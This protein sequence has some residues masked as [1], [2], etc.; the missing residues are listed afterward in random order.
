MLCEDSLHREDLVDSVCSE[1]EFVGFHV[2]AM[3]KIKLRKNQKYELNG[4]EYKYVESLLKN[5]NGV[6]VRQCPSGVA[7]IGRVL[8][9][10]NEDKK[11]KEDA[12]KIVANE[13][14]EVWIYGM[15]IYPKTIKNIISS[16]RNVYEG[17]DDGKRGSAGSGG[18]ESFRSFTKIQKRKRNDQ[19]QDRANNFNNKMLT[20]FDIRTNDKAYQDR[21]EKEHDVKMS[22]AEEETHADNCKVKTCSCLWNTRTLCKDCPRRRFADDKI[23]SSWKKWKDRKDRDIAAL[24]KQQEQNE[25]AFNTVQVYELDGDS[26]DAMDCTEEAD[27]NFKLSLKDQGTRTKGINL[28]SS[29]VPKDE[30]S[31]RQASNTGRFPEVLIRFSRKT[32]N[33]KVM[34]AVTH[35][36]ASYK[37]SSND[38]MGVAVDIANMI[39]DQQLEKEPDFATENNLSD[40]EADEAT[41]DDSDDEVRART[42]SDEKVPVQKKRRIQ[43]DLRRRFPHRTTYKEKVAS[44]R[45]APEPS[46]RCPKDHQKERGPSYYFRI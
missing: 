12:Y 26:D 42:V 17:K 36:Q 1:Q 13:L 41:D 34:R 44:S 39:F 9:L 3:S 24:Q 4:L 19:W 25:A 18:M 40:E 32:F 10:I 31:S 14:H 28:R 21:L 23:D 15:N 35:I 43:K 46:L 29:S 27:D 22:T 5:E 8:K 38:A 37:M 16:V 33:P 7:V 30:S 2:L 6:Y 11:S 20:G 45:S